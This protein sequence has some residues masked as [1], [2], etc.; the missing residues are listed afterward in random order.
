MM[1]YDFDIRNYKLRTKEQLDMLAI[2]VSLKNDIVKMIVQA[3]K[4]GYAQCE[5]DY[6][7]QCGI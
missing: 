5:N 6:R 1:P 4:D 7:I 2:P 3:Y